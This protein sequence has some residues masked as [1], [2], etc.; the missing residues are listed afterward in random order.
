[1]GFAFWDGL[2]RIAWPLAA[3]MLAAILLATGKDGNAAW[4]AFACVVA[5]AALVTA[6]A[7]RMRPLLDSASRVSGDADLSALPPVARDVF[8]RLPDPL[9]LL[10]ASGRVVFANRAMRGVI[11]IDTQRKHVS[12]LVRTP[13]VL[14]AIRRAAAS[15][16][17][18]SVEFTFPVPVQRNYQA[19]VAQAGSVTILLLHDLTAMKRAEQ[20]RADFVANASHEL[21]TP[22][23]ALSGFI[24]TL[25][26]H[27]KDDMAAR[28]QFL[29][30]MTVEAE[31][32]RRLIDDLL[33]LTRIEQNEH[34]PP[35]GRTSLETVLR[36]AVATLSP[37]AKAEGITL[38]LS[39]APG[40]PRAV[41]ERDELI[42]I[43]QN[44][45]HNAIKYGREGGHVWVTLEQGAGLSGRGAEAM[46]VT[47]V[48]DDGEGIPAAAVPRL[49]ERF[50]R[51]D[52]KRSR[53][54][55]GTG[56]GLAIVKHIVNRHQGR[57]SIESRPGEGSIFTVS[58]PAGRVPDSV[59]EM[60]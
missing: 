53:E 24:D 16:E 29:G 2:R 56:L 1:M 38:E 35:S 41:G 45:V 4:V 3:G 34:V 21:R 26:G 11:G 7:I 15:G 27:A 8:E 37:L 10:D 58:L 60:S 6:I 20:L 55:G 18:T 52:V 19:Y 50:Y 39:A 43:F 33:S 22:L 46:L 48:R 54:R 59:M 32:M 42:Q 23:A 30:I 51:V 40:L 57:L 31:R 9:M 17:A 13:S 49:T 12:A 5:L 25:K 36:E 28:E 14:D 44:L 47:T